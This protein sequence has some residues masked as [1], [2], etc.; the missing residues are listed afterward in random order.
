MVEQ[1]L[2]RL[3]LKQNDVVQFE[4]CAQVRGPRVVLT[5][6]DDFH[7]PGSGTTEH[8]VR[9]RRPEF[10]DDHIGVRKKHRLLVELDSFSG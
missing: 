8:D 7:D 2:L 3:F 5:L 6:G 9:H 10:R 4:H 1:V